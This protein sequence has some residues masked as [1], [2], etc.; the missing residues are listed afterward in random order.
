MSEPAL[1]FAEITG[2]SVEDAERFLEVLKSSLSL[3]LSIYVYIFVCVSQYL[4]YISSLYPHP[5]H[6]YLNF[7]LVSSIQYSLTLTPVVCWWKC[8]AS[9]YVIHGK[10]R[11]WFKLKQNRSSGHIFLA[12]QIRA[13]ANAQ[14][15]LKLK[16]G[17]R[18]VFISLDRRRS[19]L[20]DCFK[21]RC[22]CRE[23]LFVWWLRL[24]FHVFV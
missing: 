5:C 22:S 8:W 18:I 6:C 1:Q 2:A 17:I 12:F 11:G 16:L 19:T 20:K 3:S 10:W 4:F 14:T 13:N 7:S 23:R 24:L 21:T 15:S 9:S